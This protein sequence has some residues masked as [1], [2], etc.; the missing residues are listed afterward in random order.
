MRLTTDEPVDT[1]PG[2]GVA[3]LVDGVGGTEQAGYLGAKALVGGER[4]ER[5]PR[6]GWARK[7]TTLPDPFII[8]QAAVDVM[9]FGLQLIQVGQATW[10]RRSSGELITVSIRSARPSA[11]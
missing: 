7:D 9:G 3:H 8:E 11:G 4:G 2:Q 5:D 10:Q 1:Q 6:K